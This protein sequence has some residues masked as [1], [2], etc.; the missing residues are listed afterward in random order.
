MTASV[1]SLEIFRDRQAEQSFRSRVHQYVDAFL[2]RPACAVDTADR[3]EA[4][5]ASQEASWPSLLRLTEAVRQE[6]A[7][8]T[9]AMV[10]AYVEKGYGAYLHQE[11]A[12]CPV[13]GV[14]LKARPS[15]NRTVETLIGCVTLQRPY[16]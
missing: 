13:C 3:W 8:L 2:D 12:P 9:G 1:I 11:Y 5:M 7:T 15:R 6:R 10:G 4:R 16:F 14:L